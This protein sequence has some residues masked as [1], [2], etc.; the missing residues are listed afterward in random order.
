MNEP[1]ETFDT[2][3]A[4]PYEQGR[5]SI[6]RGIIPEGSGDGAIDLG[7]GSGV[8]SEIL[9][10][11]GWSVTAVD[12]HPKNVDRTAGRVASAIRGDAVAVCRSLEAGSF[13]F[14]CA[15]ELI[16]H[17]DE[18]ARAELLR[19]ARRIGRPGA[20]LLL[21]TPNRMSPEGLYGYY[22]GE[23]IRGVRFQAW[24][25][26]HQKIYSSFEILASLRRAGWQ[27]STVVGYH[28]QGKISLP[29]SVSYRFPLNRFGFN[30]I[31][32]SQ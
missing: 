8:V 4:D 11:R 12:L 25:P 5:L 18:N 16:E 27:P 23:L 24:D 30:I 20:S 31:V 3:Y 2:K 7:C 9:V 32:L 26:T 6:L 29:I 22:Y 14:V 1:E 13:G 10:E 19:E 28:Y 17:L 15:L 21:S